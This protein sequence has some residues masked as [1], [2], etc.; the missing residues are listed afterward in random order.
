MP[1]RRL[2]RRVGLFSGERS[3]SIRRIGGRRACRR[4]TP[5]GPPQA[6]TARATKGFS[7]FR[8]GRQTGELRYLAEYCGPGKEKRH[9]HVE[10]NEQQGY[11]IEPQIELH[12]AG[13]DRRLAALVD[14]E[15]FLVWQPRPNEPANQQVGKQEQE[16]REGKQRN[17]RGDFSR[18]S[19]L[20]LNFE[21]RR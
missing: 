11:D 21:L 13:A 4:D 2:S 18:G 20:I 5:F 1:P 9:L 17:I 12:E 16:A 7:G 3:T 14:L 19:H 10:N 8:R 6:I 15:L